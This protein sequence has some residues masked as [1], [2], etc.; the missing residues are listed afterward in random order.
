[1]SYSPYVKPGVQSSLGAMRVKPLLKEYQDERTPD[2]STAQFQ[3]LE[4]KSRAEYNFQALQSL[5][6]SYA[7]TRTPSRTLRDSSQ[8]KTPQRTSDWTPTIQ[9]TRGSSIPKSINREGIT[10]ARDPTGILSFSNFIEAE[11]PIQTVPTDY[12]EKKLYFQD[13]EIRKVAESATKYRS[14]SWRDPD[15]QTE[16]F[17]T[18]KESGL[19]NNK[20]YGY[21]REVLDL[22]VSKI[23]GVPIQSSVATEREANMNYL[24]LSDVKR[25][26]ARSSYQ[27]RIRNA[28]QSR[29]PSPFATPMQTDRGAAT[30]RR[31][32]SD[33]RFYNP[34]SAQKV[35]SLMESH[36]VSFAQQPIDYS[37]RKSMVV[38]RF[39]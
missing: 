35:N 37:N 36:D 3:K 9:T 29:E 21:P 34:I 23:M 4:P 20:F 39:S 5:K 7:P 12:D 25:E 18:L 24:T 31:C 16:Y 22:K 38:S 6:Q 2:S 30:H 8:I 33:T 17:Q 10:M 27:A 32:N 26:L 13:P 19:L 14:L 1:M 28:S 15:K 11:K